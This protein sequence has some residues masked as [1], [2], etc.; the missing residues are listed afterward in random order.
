MIRIT[1]LFSLK[2]TTSSDLPWIFVNALAAESGVFAEFFRSVSCEDGVR[3]RSRKIYNLLQHWKPS[4]ALYSKVHPLYLIQENESQKSPPFMIERSPPKKKISKKQ[5]K[6]GDWNGGFNVAHPVLNRGQDPNDPQF[7][8][9]DDHQLLQT[10]A[11]TFFC[12]NSWTRFMKAQMTIW[13]QKF[14]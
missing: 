2:E 3:Q 11:H 5:K 8:S 14:L 9:P 7:S 12:M 6:K 10:Y 1:S 4:V 13:I